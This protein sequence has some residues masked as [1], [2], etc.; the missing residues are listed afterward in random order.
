MPPKDN[1]EEPLLEVVTTISLPCT[2]TVTGCVYVTLKLN[3]A[4]AASVL[5]SNT[6]GVH[7][8]PT[9]KRGRRSDI[10]QKIDRPVLTTG[11]SQQD[12]GFFKYEWRRVED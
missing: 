4:V 2:C 12:F 7:K 3:P 5:S 6:L 8:D 10:L 11:F 9:P 1:K